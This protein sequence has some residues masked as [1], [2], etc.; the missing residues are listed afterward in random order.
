ML[1]VSVEAYY[2]YATDG[3]ISC[4]K[5]FI[6]RLKALNY[7]LS[8]QKRDKWLR[9]LINAN[10]LLIFLNISSVI[11]CQNVNINLN[12]SQLVS[13]CQNL[14][15]KPWANF[16]INNNFLLPSFGMTLFTRHVRNLMQNKTTI[17]IF[18]SNEFRFNVRN[19]MVNK[20]TQPYMNRNFAGCIRIPP[21]SKLHNIDS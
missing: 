13:N 8:T 2:M 5:W 18:Y 12:F 3:N 14:K 7:H 9:Y 15:L 19:L 21:F 16:S 11:L 1:F 17:L 4:Y 20:R 6:V 10:F